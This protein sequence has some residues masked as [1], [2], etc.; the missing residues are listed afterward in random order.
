MRVGAYTLISR[1]SIGGMMETWLAHRAGGDLVVLK[2]LLPHLSGDAELVRML[3][4]ELQC[5]FRRCRTAI[6][7]EAEHRFRS[8]AE[9]PACA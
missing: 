5:V 3:L 6:P 9:H 1:L 8:H 7:A 2:R 4:D